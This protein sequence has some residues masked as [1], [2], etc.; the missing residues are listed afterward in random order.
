METLAQA[1]HSLNYILPYDVAGKLSTADPYGNFA[2]V[3]DY[4]AFD[5]LRV[6]SIADNVPCLPVRWRKP[7]LSRPYRVVDLVANLMLA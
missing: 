2:H 4:M 5:R 7:G 3:L 6:A 1:I